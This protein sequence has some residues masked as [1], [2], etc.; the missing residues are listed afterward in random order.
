MHTSTYIGYSKGNTYAKHVE[1]LRGDPARQKNNTKY[2][3]F[4]RIL[5]QLSFMGASAIVSRGL[6]RVSR[7]LVLLS[8]VAIALGHEILGESYKM[9]VFC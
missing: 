4:C 9:S 5:L 3:R 8:S 1:T 7:G 2:V 6:A